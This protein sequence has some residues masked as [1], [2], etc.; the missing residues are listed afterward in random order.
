[1]NKMGKRFMALAIVFASIMSFL[2]VQFGSN[3]QAAN[4]ITTDIKVTATGDT[5]SIVNGEYVTLEPCENFTVSV[6]N[7][8]IKKEDIEIGQTGVIAQEIIIKS[9]DGIEL[10]G[11]DLDANNI[12][13]KPIGAKVHEGTTPFESGKRIGILIEGLPYGVNVIKY[14]IKET[15]MT[16]KKITENDSNGNPVVRGEL[17]PE[18]VTYSPDP[19]TGTPLVIQHAN[20]FV[21]NKVSPMIFNSYIGNI[22]LY[23]QADTSNEPPF[24]Y[25]KIGVPDPNC[26]LRYNF[27]VSD[28]VSTLEYIMYFDKKMVPIDAQTTMVYRNG[29]PANATITDGVVSGH[30]VKLGLSD[31]IVISINDGSNLTKSYSMQLKYNTINSNKDYTLRKAGIK[32]LYY[33]ADSS[34][35]AYIGKKFEVLDEGTGVPTYKGTINI[36]KRAQM[37]SMVPELGAKSNIAF[38]VMNYYDGG[39]IENAKI[40]N[41]EINPYVDFNKGTVNQLW[42]EVYEGKDG[43]IKEGTSA[44]VVYKLDVN[45]VEGQ[46]Q[47][48]VDFAV[49]DNAFL[50]QPGRTNEQTDKIDF[51]A[52]RRTY[53]LNFKSTATDTSTVDFELKDPKTFQKDNTT[54]RE[55]IKVWGGTSTQSDVLTEITDSTNK[56]PLVN[57]NID[58]YKKIIVQAYY[59]QLYYKPD[60]QDPTKEIVDVTKTKASPLGEKYT[61]YIAKNPDKEDPT[62]TKSSDAT[63]TNIQVSNGSIKTTDGTSGFSITK[64]NYTAQVPKIDTSSAVTITATNSKVKDITA[65]IAE[66]GDEYGLTSGEP[67]EFP[68]NTT[69]STSINIVVTA[70]DGVSKKTYNLTITND[71][72]SASA[73]LKDVITDNGDFTFDPQKDVNKI[74]VDQAINKLKVSP[75]PEQASSRVTVN[76]TKYTGSPMTIDLTG[77]QKTDM[78]ITVTSE[79]GSASK[80][81]NF[82]IYRTDSPIINP[83]DDNKADIFYDEIDKC[84]VDLS[85]YE[86]WGMA[87][88]KAV[89]FDKKGRQVKD[90]WIS[91]KGVWYYLDKS[92]Y[93]ASGWRKEVAGKTYYLDP[94]TGEVKTGW[95]NQNNKVYYLGKNGVMQKGWLQL[96]GH[97][98]Y[99]TPEGQ[100]VINQS[101][102]IDDGVYNFGTDGAMYY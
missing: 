63:L 21:Q 14:Q 22:D 55:Y 11:A 20:E 36:D 53:N 73:L 12:K 28:A 49:G 75:V 93:K 5:V 44:L 61:F 9:I 8:I 98:Y 92:G 41:G 34:V 67:F 1:M 65:K 51:S 95:L 10:D 16:N 43:N 13:L 72:R 48:T 2:P 38:K 58:N 77:S 27:D 84:W 54:R 70:E 17:Q 32:K 3:G 56:K 82:E 26:P 78:V 50:S 47:S 59:D 85:K 29:K 60:P 100:M 69:G 23:D 6:E 7:K 66:T 62:A 52:S 25:S 35:Q 18:V 101:M 90:R 19:V 79:D 40:I 76:G 94:T 81:Y 39:K 64:N 31:L 68:L 4:A 71:S 87:D 30:L 97:W 46:E 80:T 45:F 24:L 42:I 83:A 89:Y 88:G 91:T 37:I 57:V 102:Y 74:R 33:D 86:E 15:T 99:F 96:N